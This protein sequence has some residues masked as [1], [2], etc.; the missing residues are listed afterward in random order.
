MQRLEGGETVSIA[1]S[2]EK[3]IPPSNHSESVNLKSFKFWCHRSI[4]CPAGSLCTKQFSSQE[5]SLQRLCVGQQCQCMTGQ[6]CL[7]IGWA[8]LSLSCNISVVVCFM[9]LMCCCCAAACAAYRGKIDVTL[10]ADRRTD[11]T[12]KPHI[13]Y[14]ENEIYCW[15]YLDQNRCREKPTEV[16]M[17]SHQHEDTCRLRQPG[18]VFDAAHQVHQTVFNVTSCTSKHLFRPDEFCSRTA[19]MLHL[20]NCYTL[21]FKFMSVSEAVGGARSHKRTTSA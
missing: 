16:M 9:L 3:N 7:L 12:C 2:E 15:I 17:L 4:L 14:G 21:W 5:Q 19:A 8:Q 6:C 1:S 11:E 18:S 13:K 10:T 20:T